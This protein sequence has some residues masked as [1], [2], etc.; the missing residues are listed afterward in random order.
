MLSTSAMTD[1]ASTHHLAP[2][3]TARIPAQQQAIS[4]V[5]SAL[6]LWLSDQLTAPI[7]LCGP[8]GCGKRLM[9]QAI[10][11]QWL[12]PHFWTVVQLNASCWPSL[13]AKS[14]DDLLLACGSRRVCVVVDAIDKALPEH[15]AQLTETL[16]R[17]AQTK[18]L[19][20]FFICE[21]VPASIDGYVVQFSDV[22]LRQQRVDCMDE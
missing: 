8:P 2:L 11:S 18:H 10:A 20:C 16:R 3:L 7:L 22:D 9:V 5:V 21:Q 6:Q 15:L 4:G 17:H 19:L 13:L 14:T 1:Y 12:V